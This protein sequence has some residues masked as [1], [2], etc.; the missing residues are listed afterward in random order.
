MSF[1]NVLCRTAALWARPGAGIFY[2]GT[3]SM[4]DTLSKQQLIWR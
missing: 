1:S 2:L 4:D 3:D